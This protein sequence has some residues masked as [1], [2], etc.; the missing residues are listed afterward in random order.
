MVPDNAPPAGW[1]SPAPV[2]PKPVDTPPFNFINNGV[3]STVPTAINQKRDKAGNFY[4]FKCTSS[5]VGYGQDDNGNTTY[6]DSFSCNLQKYSPDGGTALWT[7]AK[8][9]INY[10]SGCCYWSV[11]TSSPYLDIVYHTADNKRLITS[12]GIYDN[13]TGAYIG[14]VPGFDYSGLKGVNQYPANGYG[15]GQIYN[16]MFEKSYQ[17]VVY[18]QRIKTVSSYN[19]GSDDSSTCYNYVIMHTLYNIKTGQIVLEIQGAAYNSD[20]DNNQYFRTTGVLTSDGKFVLPLTGYVRKIVPPYTWEQTFSAISMRVYDVLTGDKLMESPMFE[21]FAKSDRCSTWGGDIQTILTGDGEGYFRWSSDDES[22][23]SFDNFCYSSRKFT[24]SGSS[25]SDGKFS[26]GNVVDNSQ[27]LADGSMYVSVKYTDT[28][29][30]DQNGAG[31]TFRAQDNKNYYQAELTTQ[32]VV[33]NKVVNGVRTQLDKQTNPLI[34]GVYSDLKVKANKNHITVYVNGVPLIDVYDSQFSSGKV[35]IFASAP[36]LFM[37]RFHIE[38]YPN[39]S[40]TVDNVVLVDST[41]QYNVNF[42]DPENDP[43]IPQLGKWTYTNTTPQKFLDAGDGKSD[44]NATNSYVDREVNSPIASINKVGIFKISFTEPDDPAPV[45]K[46][47]P[48]NTYAA[49]RSFADPDTKLVAVHRKPISFFTVNQNADFTL[50]W[51]EGG[52]DPDRWLSSTN[53]STEKAEFATNR[54]IYQRMYGYTDPDGNVVSGM[55]TRPS[56]QGTYT[57]REAVADEYG[58][59]SDWHETSV[60]VLTPPPNN[61][62]NVVQ[63]F[64]TGTQSSPD[65]VSSLTPTVTWTQSDPDPGTIFTQARILVKDELGNTVID[66]TVTQGTT[67]ASGSWQLDTALAVGAKYQ[68][69]VMISDDAGAWSPWSSIGWIIT[70]RPPSSTMTYPTGASAASPTIVNT[71]RPGFTWSQTDPDPGTVFTYFQLQV[72]NSSGTVIYDTGQYFQGSASATQGWVPTVD[73]PANQPLQVHVRVFDGYAW[74]PYSASTWFFINR[75]PSG[76]ITFTTPIYQNDTPT[77]TVNVSDPDGNALSVKVDIS[78]NGGAYTNLMS[79]SNVASGS[80]RTFT[81]GPLNQGTYS[82]R[83]TLDDGLGGTYSQTYTFTALPLSITG[84]VTHTPEWE[85][86]RQS[87]NLMYPTKSRGAN[88]FWAGEAFE[89]SAQVTDTGSSATKPVSVSARLVQTNDTAAMSS[90][91]RINYTG[92]MLNTNFV[93]TLS[94]GPYTMRFTVQWNNGLIQTTD[95]PITIAGNIYDVIVNQLRS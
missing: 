62:P 73:M 58:A 46:R 95:V 39:N 86:Y 15:Y 74:S 52:Y 59:W 9:Y 79:W 31:I 14:Q 41:I 23:G 85:A 40:T 64:P 11:M 37:K 22:D 89:L 26:Y 49:F 94:S 4:A 33:L 17:D 77:F 71:L 54:G 1:V 61:P 5:K 32:G 69:Q 36:N 42:T 92:E 87:W 8:T 70:N 90:S 12:D 35:G 68:M 84:Q 50:T 67:S 53:Y 24:F 88:V 80:T 72:M 51:N 57:L 60:F 55:L 48:D 6:I 20:S 29:F 7:G 65:Y 3:K 82:L 83:L 93:H 19:C 66:R 43:A 75:P 21:N 28:T 56:K 44:T 2:P 91:N 27:T 38:K 63:T 34:P 81:Y 16:N 78:F 30:S 45:G 13:D 47:Y 25:T 10:D 18:Y 76:N